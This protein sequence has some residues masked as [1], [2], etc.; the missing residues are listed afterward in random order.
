MTMTHS[1]HESTMGLLGALPGAAGLVNPVFDG[2]GKLCDLVLIWANDQLCGLVGT[3]PA[4]G[5]KLSQSGTPEKIA[6]WLQR[7]EK[8]RHSTEID[9][10]F[11]SISAG[12]ADAGDYYQLDMRWWDDRLILVATPLVTA[13]PDLSTALRAAALLI[14]VLP[15]LPVSYGVLLGERWLHYPTPSLMASLGATQEEFAA[16]SLLEMV[17]ESDRPSAERW[18]ALPQ[19]SRRGPF[20]FRSAHVGTSE[21]WLELWMALVEPGTTTFAAQE[22]ANVYVLTDVD[23]RVRLQ[24]EHEVLLDWQANQLDVMYSALN[25]SHEGMAI[26]KAVR[27]DDG[28]VTSFDLVFI[29]EAPRNLTA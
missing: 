23:A 25:A 3:V 19:D 6:E 18:L 2:D 8:N 29:N 16:L 13:K 22:S 7:L 15:D 17:H 5:L 12:R 28:Q 26:W 14:K 27:D 10:H 9:R 11:W 4:A 1:V 20:L 24:S 21:R